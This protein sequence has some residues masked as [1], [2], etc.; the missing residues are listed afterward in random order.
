MPDDRPGSV[1]KVVLDSP[2]PRLD[3][4]FDYRVPAALADQVVPGVRVKVPLRVAGRVADGWVVALADTTEAPGELSPIE[5]VVSAAPVLAPEVWRLARAVADRGAGVASDVLRI[6]V[7]KRQARVEQRWLAADR[8]PSGAIDADSGPLADALLAGQRI[9]AL[10]T[11]HVVEA[12][13]EWVG[14]W[15]ADVARVAAAVAAAGRS[16]IVAVPD[17]RDLDQLETALAAGPAADLVLRIDATPPPAARYRAHLAALEPGPHVLIGN[18][19]AVYAPAAELGAIV[20]W[21]EADPFHQEPLAP[22]AATRDVALLRQ[23]QS[24]AGLLLLSSTR[25]TTVQRLVD[26]AW[27]T[28]WE[29]VRGRPNVVLTPDD[30]RG[31][32]I[33]S[34]AYR[35]VQQALTAG[36]V[37]VQV[38]KPGDAAL[39]ALRA[40]E[41]PVPIDAG[42]TAHELGRAFPGVPVLIADGEHVH[43]TVPGGPRL[44]VSTRGAEPRAPGG[45]R[46]VLLLDGARMLLRESLWVAEDCLRWWASAA[47]LA[48]PDA[49]VHLVGVSGDVA[50][51]LAT[52]RSPDFAA[53]QLADRR[54][55]RFPP[56]VRLASATGP[57]HA[58]E[59]LVEAWAGAGADLLTRSREERG[60]RAVVRFPTGAGGRVASVAK[61]ALIR[62]GSARRPKP[63]APP[64]PVLRVRFDPHEPL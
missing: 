27:C 58:V 26:L 39:K 32:R 60:E 4:L 23:G 3:H 46:A 34:A 37:L 12:G 11:P 63:P 36:P 24:G 49:P 50:T 30:G 2:L 41:A 44:V 53:R 31:A 29:I 51:A 25:S 52:W 10:P 6:A 5:Q 9:A 21:E 22:Y 59:D 28:P 17:R 64:P 42:R 43:D 62:H 61:Q 38:S 16:T 14:G 19:S 7:P 13:G 56:V 8:R 45:Y 33:P 20:V 40:G 1:A 55:L 47:M 15:A 54:E 48:A 18:R 35:A 57:V